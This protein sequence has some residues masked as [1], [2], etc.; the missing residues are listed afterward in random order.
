MLPLPECSRARVLLTTMLF[1]P[2]YNVLFGSHFYTKLL[3]IFLFSFTV[4]FLK[5]AIYI[6][7]PPFSL[8]PTPMRLSP[9]TTP[10][11]FLSAKVTVA[12][13]N[14]QFSVFIVFDAVDHS[15]LLGALS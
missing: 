4:K 12:K 8:E 1:L 13:S 9:P 11:K 15:F 5:R 3:P 2:S 10:L 6:P 7:F 14:G